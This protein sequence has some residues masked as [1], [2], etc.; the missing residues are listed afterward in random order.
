MPGIRLP[1]AVYSLC[2]PAMRIAGGG[3]V[4]P[5]P[6][7]P[8]HP[9]GDNQRRGDDA[10]N[11][12]QPSPD[13]TERLSRMERVLPGEELVARACPVVVTR[14]QDARIR[15]R[16]I[17]PQPPLIVTVAPV[18]G[19]HGI[20]G[21]IGQ[22]TQAV[23]LRTVGSHRRHR[24]F[25]PHRSRGRLD[26]GP[27]LV[28]P[29]VVGRHQRHRAAAVIGPGERH[30]DRR[31]YIR[32]PARPTYPAHGASRTIAGGCPAVSRRRR[33]CATLPAPAPPVI[34]T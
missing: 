3:A 5:P 18:E 29:L 4:L 6:A 14:H 1:R 19:A 28:K 34:A 15:H 27:M 31:E 22:D 24:R 30:A 25:Q 2:Y 16:D 9:A 12:D 32:S 26:I 11:E 17:G 7:Q 21:V 13:R 23:D 33:H 10:G 8:Q 20:G